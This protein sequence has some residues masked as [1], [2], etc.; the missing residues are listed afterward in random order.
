[1]MKFEMSVSGHSLFYRSSI[2]ALIVIRLSGEVQKV[3]VRFKFWVAVRV[4]GS[5][6]KVRFGRIY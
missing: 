6:F 5:R 2:D 1:M 3:R 4:L